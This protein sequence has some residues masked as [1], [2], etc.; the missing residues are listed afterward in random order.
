MSEIVIEVDG[1]W[2]IFRD[3]WLRPRVKALR[4]IDLQVEKGEVFGLLGPNGSGKSTTIQILLGLQFPTRGKVS[5]LG[6]SPGSVEC[7]KRIGYLPED[8]V[9]YPFLTGREM[10][11]LCARLSQV[12]ISDRETRVEALLEMVGL[13]TAA[14]R[15]IGD[16]SK[17]MQRRIG[18]AQALIHDPDLIILDEPTNGLDPIGVRQVKDWIC[19]LQKRGKTILITSHLLSDVEEVCDRV[20]ILYGGKVQAEGAVKEIL[21]HQDQSRW[22]T[23]T[24]N[25]DQR[26]KLHGAFEE[27]GIK[28]LSM[29]S[30]RRS[31]EDKFLET[32]QSAR[33]EG[34]QTEGAEYGGQLPDF[35]S[36][37]DNLSGPNNLSGPDGPEDPS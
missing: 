35:L 25:Q 18:V 26:E 12:P 34:E 15:E 1:L 13:T 30:S 9:F 20:S 14:D 27:Q 16:Y 33:K 32:V 7:K 4:G 17:G 3:F 10:L 19:A 6:T 28:I 36:S 2:K 23:A 37:S 22:I 24:P 5:I 29:E 31:L 11:T 21:E 8:S